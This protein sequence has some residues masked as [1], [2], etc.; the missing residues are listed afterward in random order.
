MSCPQTRELAEYEEGLGSDRRRHR[1]ARHL[2]E[3]PRC[4]QEMLALQRTAQVLRAV[5]A[6]AMPDDLWPGVAARIAALPRR[7][8]LPWLWRTAAGVGLAASLLLG[9]LFNRPSA[10]LP[11]APEVVTPY[12]AQHQLLSTRDALSDR[13]SLASQLSTEQG[14]Q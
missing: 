6:P 13:A 4:R 1:L 11:S 9:L 14:N 10:S 7:S 2:T 5:P 12:V 3:C 8:A